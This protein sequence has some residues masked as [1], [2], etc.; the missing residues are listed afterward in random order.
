[1]YIYNTDMLLT[2][3]Y[4]Y[5]YSLPHDDVTIKLSNLTIYAYLRY[6]INV[7]HQ[8]QSG[9]CVVVFCREATLQTDR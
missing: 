3:F 9:S 2:P 6:I 5:A 7:R 1:M 8:P 4:H